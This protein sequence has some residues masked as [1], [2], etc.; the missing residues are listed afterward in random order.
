MLA[1][2]FVAAIVAVSV[3]CISS[4]EITAKSPAGHTISAVLET[5]RPSIRRPAV[6]LVS[7][8]G[9]HT[10]DYSTASSDDKAN[11]AFRELAR[12][13]LLAGFAVVRF[14]E[15]GTGLSTG[16]YARTA[17]TATLAED[18]QALITVVVRR[19]EVDPNRIILVGHSEGSVIATIVAGR[20]RS[21]A[22]IALLSAPAW[23][24]RRIMEWQDAYQLKYGE[25]SSFRPTQ[26]SR[27]EWLA[28][29]RQRRESAD[30]WF[31]FFLDYDPLPA[32]RRVRVPILIL[33]GD[34]DVH[35]TPDQATEIAQ[36]ATDAGNAR[37][38]LQV[39]PGLSHSLGD[40]ASSFPPP[41]SASVGAKLTDWLSATLGYRPRQRSCAA[42][43]RAA[44]A[45]TP[46]STTA[47]D[48]SAS[49][50]APVSSTQSA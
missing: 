13:L 49:P 1:P 4:S 44:G 2:V 39:L 47:P 10:R 24:G 20:E 28:S 45:A 36:A 30:V 21:V 46:P 8:S 25:W 32:I 41:L 18:V 37:V 43:R 50:I 26:E 19:A 38:T 35:V 27:L 16:D 15:R 11:H 7:G 3:P 22:A 34:A 33:H 29:E 31:P 17:T 12:Q 9:P 23:T 40:P 5:G 6:I 42:P 48:R 14:D